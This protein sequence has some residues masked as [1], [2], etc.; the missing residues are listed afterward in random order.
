MI[1]T[2][3]KNASSIKMLSYSCFILVSFTVLK[4]L[5]SHPNVTCTF[6]CCLEHNLG[7]ARISVGSF[8]LSQKGLILR[9]QIKYPSLH[10][11]ELSH[12]V[13]PLVVSVP[14]LCAQ[15]FLVDFELK[16]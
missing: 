11:G 5:S 15:T 2:A 4:C 13:M 16:K 10:V 8:S 3:V 9:L 6:L 12:R 1:H 14:S 7:L